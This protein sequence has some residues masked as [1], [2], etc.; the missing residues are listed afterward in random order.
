ML[1]VGALSLNA[2]DGCNKVRTQDAAPPYGMSAEWVED[3]HKK[4]R[5]LDAGLQ[6]KL[7]A[8]S[9]SL[10][11]AER[12]S[13]RL[14]VTVTNTIAMV[15]APGAIGPSLLVDNQ[16]S[17][18]LGRALSECMLARPWPQLPL[19]Q[20][21]Q[22]EIVGG[23]SLLMTPGVHEITL[24]TQYREAGRLRVEIKK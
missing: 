14:K 19:G 10:T 24:R 4:M 20:S 5:E 7:E 12:A 8:G 16:P 21:A 22:C 3:Y 11:E 15:A 17:I 23:D 2:C 1:T 13:W 9:L 18:E 6:W